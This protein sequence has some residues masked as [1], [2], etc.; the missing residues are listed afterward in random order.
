MLYVARTRHPA[1][2]QAGTSARWASGLHRMDR[3][4]GRRVDAIASG[5]AA[6]NPALPRDCWVR[7]SSASVERV[8]RSDTRRDDDGFRRAQPI[9]TQS[10]L[11]PSGN[12]AWNVRRVDLRFTWCCQ[13][14]RRL[15]VLTDFRP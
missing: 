12:I 9:R 11:R 7:R 8:E 4:G 2:K 6:A 14:I 5:A 15:W 3:A 13:I 10:G 1:A